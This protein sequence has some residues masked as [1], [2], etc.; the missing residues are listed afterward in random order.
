MSQ[1]DE[2]RKAMDAADRALTALYRAQE[3]LGS[4]RSWGIADLLGGGPLFTAM[5]QHRMREANDDLAAARTALQ[6]F[7]KEL[8]DVDP[9]DL[10]NIELG[11]FLSFADFF[12]DGA[13]ADWLMQSRI[14][15]A[16]AQVDRAIQQVEALLHKLQDKL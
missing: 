7:A 11:D 2:I 1:A 16:R 13:L 15:D 6:A 8:R 14:K 5:K 4:A 10:S 3:R 12:F 9:A